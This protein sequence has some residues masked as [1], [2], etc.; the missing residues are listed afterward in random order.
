MANQMDKSYTELCSERTIFS[1]DQGFF[2][3]MLATIKKSCSEKWLKNL[4]ESKISDATKIKLLFDEPDVSDML[5]GTLEHVQ[6]VYR[7]K[8]CTFSHERRK[9]GEIL[10]RKGELNNALVLLTQAILRA[11]SKGNFCISFCVFDAFDGC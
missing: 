6:S 1:D 2:G 9:Q 7:P 5:L 11:P 10:H 4:F 3:E 8:E